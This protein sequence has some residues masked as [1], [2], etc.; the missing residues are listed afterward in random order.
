VPVAH[1]QSAGFKP[2][3]F[4]APDQDGVHRNLA[5]GVGSKGAAA[6]ANLSTL[7][8][9]VQR[10]FSRLKLTRGLECGHTVYPYS[11]VSRLKKKT[12]GALR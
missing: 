5:Y 11:I 12:E 10:K 4:G 8:L 1:R 3:E 9:E 2:R 7:N 6:R